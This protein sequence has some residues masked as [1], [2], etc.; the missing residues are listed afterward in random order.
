MVVPFLNYHGQCE[1]AIGFYEKIFTITNKKVQKFGD[2]PGVPENMKN[3]ILHAELELNGQPFW[4]GD[5]PGEV[6]E[7]TMITISV[8]YQDPEKVT[9]VFNTLLE[10]GSVLI[11]LSPKPYSPMHGCVKDKFG[12]GWQI[13]AR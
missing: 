6:T 8:T 9:E 2:M 1:E 3:Y 7:G 4:F 12:I 10:G 13:L 5:S 11:E